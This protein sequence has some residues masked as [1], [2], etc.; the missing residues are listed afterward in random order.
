MDFQLPN[1][2]F[3]KNNSQIETINVMSANLGTKMKTSRWVK[4]ELVKEDIDIAG[5]QET[6]NNLGDLIT[7][8]GWNSHC[9]KGLCLMSKF[10]FVYLE[11]ESDL[12][13]RSGYSTFVSLYEIEINGRKEKLLN[14]HLET[15]RKA[16]TGFSLKDMSLDS[17]YDNAIQRYIE[18]KKMSEL[19]AKYNPA[20]VVGDFNM[21]KESAIYRENFSAYHNAFEERGFGFGYTKFTSL[22]GVRIDHIL[23]SDTFYPI[24]AVVGSDV[25][26]DHKP[27]IATLSVR[28][29]EIQINQYA[30]L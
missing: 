27:M 23:S 16:Y 18:A 9:K 10:D 12:Y 28:P 8:Q 26:S 22:H 17:F 1:I 25:G 30:K 24:R 4:K 29:Y 20:I 3:G 15:P 2:E 6:P 19:M 11:K 14:V 7:P 13:S 5:F 21:P